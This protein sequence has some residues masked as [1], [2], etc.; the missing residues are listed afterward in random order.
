MQEKSNSRENS[1]G[2]TFG[3]NNNLPREYYSVENTQ[4]IKGYK[5]PQKNVFRKRRQ[6]GTS[7]YG[8]YWTYFNKHH[9]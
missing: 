7:K 1:V 5:C 8:T 2:K 4:E 9:F 6:A 3:Q